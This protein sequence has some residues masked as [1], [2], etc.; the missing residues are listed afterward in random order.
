MSDDDRRL[1]TAELLGALTYGQLR[2]YS[3]AARVV[4]LAPTLREAEA[5]VGF[6]T[7]ERERYERLRARVDELTDLSP[8][9]VERQRTAFDRYFDALP[10]DS[11]LG[12]LVFLAVG[13]PIAGDF[14]RGV[15]P[16]LDERSAQVVLDTLDR[17]DDIEDVAHAAL[18]EQLD[19]PD[20]AET[21][22]SMV[23]D[24]IGN[25]LTAFTGSLGESDALKRLFAALA[26][27]TEAAAEELVKRT[28][29]TVLAQHRRRMHHLGLDDIE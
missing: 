12:A 6:A 23:A 26:E 1:A 27:T 19:D 14:A 17:D 2:A 13:L 21:A 5:L 9:V 3:A 25:A 11:W 16:T 8:A 28:A 15:A 29:L 7:R 4:P 20:V 22:R 18:R 10:L 24:V